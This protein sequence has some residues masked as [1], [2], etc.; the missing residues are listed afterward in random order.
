MK[1]SIRIASAAAGILALGIVPFISV[2]QEVPATDPAAATATTSSASESTSVAADGTV[3]AT[4]EAAS[5]SVA[6]DG[7]V[8]TTKDSSSTESSA[9][10]DSASSQ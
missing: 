3:T 5:T 8:T 2:A 9:S 4:S 10:S 7:T 6:A 1:S